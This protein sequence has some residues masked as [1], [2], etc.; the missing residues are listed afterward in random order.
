MS[1]IRGIDVILYNS[2]EIGRDDFNN[3][4]TE[5]TAITVENVLVTPVS[6][7]DVLDGVNLNGK[8]AVYQLCIPKGDTNNWTNAVVEFYG[9]KWRTIG[10]PK[11]YIEELLPLSWNKQINVER[12]E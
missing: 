9:E 3:P 8:T 7:A 10:V 11:Q 6:T 2:I 5:E 1:I 4:I 12:Y